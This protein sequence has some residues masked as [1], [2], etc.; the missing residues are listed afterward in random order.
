MSVTFDCFSF[1]VSGAC[2]PTT[3]ASV[4]YYNMVT[5]SMSTSQVEAAAKKLTFEVVNVTLA[6]IPIAFQMMTASLSDNMIMGVEALQCAMTSGF[7]NVWKLLAAASLVAKEFG[8][9]SYINEGVNQ[10]YPYVCTCRRDVI[11]LSQWLSPNSKET[12]LEC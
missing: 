7:A 6:V 3:N 11:S 9:T 12:N 4:P 5:D 10:V 1:T 2:D 8:M